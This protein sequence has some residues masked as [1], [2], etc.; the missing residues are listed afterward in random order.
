[1]IVTD[2]RVVKFVGSKIDR[3]IYPPFTAIGLERDG[4]IVSGVI[5]NCFTGYDLNVTVAGSYFPRSFIKAVGYYVFSQLGCLRMSITTDQPHV[6]ELSHRL[7]AQTEGYKKNHFGQG[8]DATIL[9]IL[10]EDWK[11]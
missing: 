6:I 3:I 8:K 7:N 5:F 2:D 4:K 9:G 10:R 1:M 11:F